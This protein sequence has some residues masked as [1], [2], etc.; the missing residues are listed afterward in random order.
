MKKNISIA[1]LKAHPLNR[2]FDRFGEGWAALVE[3]VREHGVI[4]PPLV[5]KA[6]DF[7]EIVAGHRRVAAA[8]EAGIVEL[9][10]IVRKMDD[11]AALELLVIENLERENPDPVEEGRLLRALADEG[12]EPEVLAHRLKRG[13]AWITTRQRLLDLGDEVLEAVRKPK[14]AAGHL[15]MGAVEVILMVPE[16]ERPRAI[17]MVLHPEWTAEVLGQREAAEV[18]RT[19]ILEPARKK[20]AWEKEAPSLVKAW[21]KGLGTYLTKEER[22]DLVVQAIRYEEAETCRLKMEAEDLIPGD[23]LEDEAAHDVA[24]RWVHLAVAHGLPVWVVPQ[25]ECQVGRGKCEEG[26]VAVVDSAMLEMAEKARADNGLSTMLVVDKKKRRKSRVLGAMAAAL[27]ADADE[28]GDPDY[29]DS[30]PPETVIEQTMESR[31]WVDLG[32]VRWLRENYD[33]CEGT[34]DCPE[35]ARELNVKD[36]S[37]L[38][39]AVCDWILELNKS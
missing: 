36:M 16:E 25:G 38:I 29:D 26:S 10:C 32:P 11:R 18:I 1:L 4:Q 39:P 27:Q 19:A 28:G 30:E 31:A 34:E 20:A 3:S 12:V 13:V 24:P 6:G 23:L 15:G 7:H 22:K 37:H 5:R 8:G 35:W 21:R 33:T 2:H 9:E 17:Q 14:D